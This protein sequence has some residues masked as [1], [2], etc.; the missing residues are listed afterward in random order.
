MVVRKETVTA[1]MM[2][3]RNKKVKVCSPVGDT[4]F[5]DIVAG[6]LQENTLAP[7]LLIICQDNALKTLLDPMK[8]NGFKLKKIKKARS[9]RYPTEIITDA[10]HV[11]DIAL[12]AN[13]PTQAESLLHRLRQAAGG[14]V[15]NV[16]A[17]KTEYM[18]F[19]REGAIST[20]NGGSLNLGDKF[21]YIGISRLV[22]LFDGISTFVGYL[23]P[24]LFS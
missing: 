9:R 5:F 20:L 21:M 13:T 10:G 18:C 19:N 1:I 3:Y 6:V 22:S 15:L 14:S 8:E 4:D 11:D 2:L 7:Y 24:K 16:N 23:M 17:S 12:L